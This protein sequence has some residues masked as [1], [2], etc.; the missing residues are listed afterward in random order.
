MNP[1]QRFDGLDEA[2]Q[3][4]VQHDQERR[5]RQREEPIAA[6]ESP[7][8]EARADLLL[9]Q[10]RS[11]PSA[12]RSHAELVA[13]VRGAEWLVEGYA[14]RNT[15]ATMFGESGSFKSTIALDLAL[16]V[17]SGRSYYGKRVQQGGV[18]MIAGEG[19]AGVTRRMMAWQKAHGVPGALPVYVTDR[20]F[21]LDREVEA[22]E[23]ADHVD[24]MARKFG[25]T[26]AMIVID[27]LN[28]NMEGDENSSQDMS[29]FVNEVSRHLKSRFNAFVLVVHHVGHGGKNRERGSTAL[30]GAVDARYR[31]ER[32]GKMAA[33]LEVMKMK[34]GSEPESLRFEIEVVDV[35]ITDSFGNRQTSVAVTR[36][37]VTTVEPRGAVAKVKS[38]HADFLRCLDECVTKEVVVGDGVPT[39]A[40]AA[41]ADAVRERYKGVFKGGE[42]PDDP[43][44]ARKHADTCGTTFD[45]TRRELRNA[46]QIEYRDGLIWRVPPASAGT[47][48]KDGQNE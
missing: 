39:D 46:G 13:D 28:R 3:P 8:V 7:S 24:R 10:S 12:F 45:R 35:G 1:D 41:K 48:Y 40:S 44:L 34:D 42:V 29:R 4:H 30:P 6:N 2:E 27:T 26:P 9:A 25:V 43:E 33:T 14:E 36:A 22:K 5:A 17:A 23:I 21:P 32:K 38:R 16:H 11:T 20:A 18:F 31:V 37:A 19:H 15:L 47:R